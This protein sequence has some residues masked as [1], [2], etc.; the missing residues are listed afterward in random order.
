M[1]I[2]DTGI[3]TALPDLA[4]HHPSAHS[5]EPNPPL[6]S[7]GLAKERLLILPSG[8]SVDNSDA[9]KWKFPDGALLVKTFF[10]DSGPNKAR[11]PIETRF[12]RH[13]QDPADPFSEWEFAVYAWNA[14]STDA[15]LVSF[16]DPMKS[17]PVQVVV[18]RMEGGKPLRL[19]NGQPF[20]HQIPSK[21]D[22]QSCH[23]ANAKRTEADVI[24]FDELRLNWKLPGAA[25]TQLETLVEQKVLTTL[26][27][28]PA[29]ISE[30][31]PLLARVEAWVYGNCVHCHNG[32][33]GMLDLQPGVFVANTVNQA[34][35]GAGIMPPSADWKRV[36][37]KQPEKSI[38]FVQAR[39]SP[40]PMGAGIQM[41][42][43]PPVGV[44]EVDSA[45]VADL[46]DWI[47]S[48]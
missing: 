28:A 18:D 29:T 30:A 36:V 32:A 27:A 47:T 4:Q 24:G 3:F 41:R 25:K 16:D 19:N 23:D 8:T 42:A 5:F 14:D 9:A 22:C 34:S 37:P 44:T 43:M 11:R 2:K 26:P 15:A 48:L 6:W 31:S 1:S 10:D 46:S 17:T 12:L 7:D 40:L 21:Q 35:Q 45:A 33:E 13:G 38:L 39:R 20:T